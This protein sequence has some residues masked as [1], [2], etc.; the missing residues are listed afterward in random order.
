MPN[1]AMRYPLASMRRITSPIWPRAT[2]SGLTRTRVRSTADSVTRRSLTTAA[3]ARSRAAGRTRG[4]LEQH[5][6]AA[7]RPD[8]LMP[9]HQDPQPH[10]DEQCTDEEHRRDHDPGREEGHLQSGT[11]RDAPRTAHHTGAGHEQHGESDA[12]AGA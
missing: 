4:S 11:D 3:K 5:A 2:P 8:D 6:D 1:A 7:G 9:E 10:R 12:D